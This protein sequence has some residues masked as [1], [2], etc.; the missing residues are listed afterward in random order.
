MRGLHLLLE[1]GLDAELTVLQ[2]IRG[3]YCAAVYQSEPSITCSWLCRLSLLSSSSP[4]SPYFLSAVTSFCSVSCS[5]YTRNILQVKIFYRKLKI[6]ELL[7]RLPQLLHT[8][9][10]TGGQLQVSLPA[11]E[12]GLCQHNLMIIVCC[13]VPWHKM[14]K[15]END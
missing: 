8:Q 5:S 3:Q 14:L 9:H 13:L 2:P 11:K 1:L 15:T 6:F 12:S 4:S 7:Q 10:L